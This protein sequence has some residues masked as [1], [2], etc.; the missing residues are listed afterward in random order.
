MSSS[1]AALASHIMPRSWA[2][3]PVEIDQP[4][5][6]VPTR[7]SRGT[8]TSSKN[9]SLKST[10]SD[11]LSS[12]NGRTRDARRLHV[13]DH[14]ADA[15]V[16]RRVG[17]GAHEA[18]AVVGVVRSRGPDLLAADHEV[19]AV[20]LGARRQAG[21]VAARAGLA[22][23]QAPGDLGAQRR[24]QVL[25]LEEVAAV[26]EDRRRDDPQSLG[27]GACARPASSPSPR[28]RR[29]AAREAGSGPRARGGHP[30]TSSPAS[31][32]RRCQRRDQPVRCAELVTGSARISS[33]VGWFAVEPGA[34]LGAECLGVGVVVQLHVRPPA[35]RRCAG[36]AR[37]P[38]RR[39]PR[40]SWRA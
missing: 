16:L 32:R 20:H 2:S 25:L 40:A 35:G 38:F 22:H 39:A 17:V 27:I 4:W 13:D 1:R 33:S 15:A 23:S 7:W 34:Q 28:G 37:R 21:E 26:V 30:G 14:D 31:N 29:A 8:T 6:S 36:G 19:V 9:T 11:R 3:E 12:G 24:Q 10:W 18:E 5:F